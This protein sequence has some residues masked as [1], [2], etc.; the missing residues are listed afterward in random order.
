LKPVIEINHLYFGYDETPILEDVT[1]QIMPGELIG[2]IGPNGGGKTTLLKLILGL[3]KPTKGTIQVFGKDARD[4]NCDLAYVPQRVHLD[5][6]FPISVREVVLAGRLHHAGWFGPYSKRDQEAAMRAL[7]KVGME[8]F[9]HR[10]FGTLSGGQAQRVLIARAL[11]CDPKLLLLD[12]PTANVDRETE[13]ALFDLIL[14]LKEEMTI[15]MV[16]HDLQTVID[17]VTRVVCVQHQ[18]TDITRDRV[19]DHFKVGLYHKP[20]QITPPQ[21]GGQ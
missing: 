20:I 2:V 10:T 6:L 9:G 4:A 21:E 3:L 5:P 14:Q 19:C 11:V 8:K 17:L 1:L 18:V 16:T 7:E 12:E 15:I 13:K